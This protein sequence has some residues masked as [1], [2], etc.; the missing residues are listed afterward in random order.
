VHPE[1]YPV[2]RTH[3]GRPARPARWQQLLGNADVLKRARRRQVH[4][5]AFGLPTVQRHPQGTGEA[6]PRPA[7]EFKTAAFQEGVEDLKDLKPGM[8]LE[9]V[10]TNVTNFGAFVDIGVHQDGLVHISALSEKFV[11]DPREVVKA[12]DIVK[13]KVLEVDLARKRIALTMRHAGADQCPT[14]PARRTLAHGFQGSFS[15]LYPRLRRASGASACAWAATFPAELQADAC[16]SSVR[17]DQPAGNCTVAALRRSSRAFID[18]RA[19]RRSRPALRLRTRC[20]TSPKSATAKSAAQTLADRLPA[21]RR[22]PRTE[23]HCSRW[24]SIPTSVK[25]RCSPRAPVAP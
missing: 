14:R 22:Q 17:R 20:P 15:E 2:V 12:G 6:R 5:R 25:A 18:Q 7:P 3:P 1:A 24:S 23:K 10:V 19:R 9:G 21:G 13:V 16:A 11:K 8:Q 4:R